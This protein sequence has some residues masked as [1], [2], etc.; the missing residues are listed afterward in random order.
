M[1]T[2]IVRSL[3]C[4]GLGTAAIL[5]CSVSA[6]VLSGCGVAPYTDTTTHTLSISGTAFG[7]QPP[8]SNASVILFATGSTGYGSG[9]SAIGT[10]TTDTS[11]NF[12][13]T[14]FTPCADPQQVYI[15][16]TGGNPGLTAG[17]NN[18]AIVLAAALGNC[19]TISSS[20]HVDHQRGHDDRSS[21]RAE[22]LRQPLHHPRPR[23][24]RHKFDQSVGAYPRL[25]ER[26]QHR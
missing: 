10:A 20:T 13:I 18:T 26:S 22:R 25:P 2:P 3:S 6:W 4:K 17:T 15:V 8:I 24:H 19:S 7:G 14:G 1:R 21:L 23:L 5:F 16:A 12:Q 9:A 11:G